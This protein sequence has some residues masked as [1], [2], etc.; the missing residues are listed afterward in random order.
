[1]RNYLN[2]QQHALSGYFKRLAQDNRFYA[3]HI[4]LMMALFYYSDSD[5]PEQPFQVSRPKLMQFSRIR[6]TSTYHKNIQDLVDGGY[7]EYTPSWHPML[8]SKVR[9][10]LQTTDR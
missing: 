1:M 10:I 8:G 3:S 5:F 2:L 9:F 7:I 4:S 6:S